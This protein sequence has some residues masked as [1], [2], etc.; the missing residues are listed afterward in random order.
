MTENTKQFHED[1]D[2]LHILPLNILPLRHRHL[3]R[4]RMLKNS[5]MEGVVEVLSGEETGGGQIYPYQLDSTY[6]F[7]GDDREDLPIL[8]KLSALPSY[9][10]YSLRIELRDMNI[11][12]NKVE[13]LKLSPGKKEELAG[14]MTQFTRPLMKAVYGDGVSGQDNVNDV[15][16]ML[17]DPDMVTARANLDK[18]SRALRMPVSAIPSFLERYGD[19][20]LSLSYYQQALDR[21]MEALNILMDELERIKKTGTH[22]ALQETCS[23]IRNGLLGIVTEVTNIIGVF[24]SQ[25]VQ[26]WEQVSADRFQETADHITSYH[27]RLGAALCLIDVKLRTWQTRFPHPTVGNMNQRA[28]FL[29]SDIKP[30]LE[31]QVPIQ[32]AS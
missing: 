7:V 24:K 20:Y 30:G 22:Y 17:T 9:D 28:S 11:D 25:T 4:T 10:V 2:S 18:I 12:V 14:Y 15:L 29:I 6:V 13:H 16:G 31:K 19:I 21:N 32:M 8:K 23:T 27:T 1:M 26:M 3:L 5:R